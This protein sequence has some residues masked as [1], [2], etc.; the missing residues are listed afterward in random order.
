VKNLDALANLPAVT[1][2]RVSNFAFPDDYMEVINS[3]PELQHFSYTFGRAPFTGS[4]LGLI[5]AP[6][7]MLTL[8]LYGSPIGSKGAEAIGRCLNLNWLSLGYSSLADK[9][10]LHLAKLTSLT[11]LNLVGAPATIVGLRQLKPLTL[12]TSFGWAPQPKKGK[13]DGAELA[14]I[15]PNIE[16]LQ[17]GGREGCKP[18][19]FSGL[20]AW[21]KLNTLYVHNAPDKAMMTGLAGLPQVTHLDGYWWNSLTD[22]GLASLAMS[23]SLK[24]IKLDFIPGVTRAGLLHFA[25]MAQLESLSLQRAGKLTPAD[26]E[27]FRSLRPDVKLNVSK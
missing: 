8:N 14:A 26:A 22:E 23:K 5:A 12:L 16:W 21:T 24:S 4:K 9:D 7:K 25:K 19:D 6:E 10:C 11:Y 17:L 2:F 27:A 18:E 20:A 1:A 3:Y 13:A 15:L